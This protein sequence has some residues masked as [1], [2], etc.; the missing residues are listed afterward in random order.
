M[1]TML[2]RYMRGTAKKCISTPWMV[3][4]P[5]TPMSVACSRRRNDNNAEDNE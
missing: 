2:V 4:T 5:E 1:P 3:R